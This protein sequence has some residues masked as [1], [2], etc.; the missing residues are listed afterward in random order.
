MFGLILGVD[1]LDVI[2][3]RIAFVISLVQLILLVSIWN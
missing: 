2:Y 1:L 3:N